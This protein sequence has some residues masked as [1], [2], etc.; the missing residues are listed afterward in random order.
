VNDTRET[1]KKKKSKLG[2]FL[3]PTL[4]KKAKDYGIMEKEKFILK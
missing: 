1:I 2:G 3:M 4:K